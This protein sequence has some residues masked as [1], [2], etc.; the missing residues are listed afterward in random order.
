MITRWPPPGPRLASPRSRTESG[1]RAARSARSALR[2]GQPLVG[3]DRPGELGPAA[4]VKLA[5]DLAQV[6]FDSA[7]AEEQPGG[8]LPVGQVPGDQPGDL[9]LLRGEHVRGPGAARTGPLA[10]GAQ[11]ARGSFCECA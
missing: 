10:G 1:S 8:D 2:R 9:L 4:D 5:E 6:V 3:A 7:G 11:L